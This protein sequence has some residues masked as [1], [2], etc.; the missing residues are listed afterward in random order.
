LESVKDIN[1]IST[2]KLVM[3]ISGSHWEQKNKGPHFNLK[4]ESH[5]NLTS[6]CLTMPQMFSLHEFQ[7]REYLVLHLNLSYLP[8]H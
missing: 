5:K 6:T 2:C 7:Q 8:E 4:H 3:Q 1:V